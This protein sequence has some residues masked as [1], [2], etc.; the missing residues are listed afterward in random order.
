MQAC[1]CDIG[2]QRNLQVQNVV[3]DMLQDFHLANVLVLGDAGH[4]LLQL[5]V[6]VIHVVQQ[7]ER[8]I[9]G[10]LAPRDSQRVLGQSRAVFPERP[11]GAY[12]FHVVSVGS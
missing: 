3:D 11:Y 8:I 1:Y 7:A 5:G 6:A 12:C 9:H 4:Q 2:V 10:C